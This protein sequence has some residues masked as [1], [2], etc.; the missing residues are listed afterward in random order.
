MAKDIIYG[1]EARLKIKEGV[2][3]MWQECSIRKEIWS[4]DNN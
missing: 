4:I 1:N 3:S 2:R